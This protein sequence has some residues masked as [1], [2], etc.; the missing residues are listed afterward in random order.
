MDVASN[1]DEEFKQRI[2]HIL[3]TDDTELTLE[4]ENVDTI[5]TESVSEHNNQSDVH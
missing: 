3:F 5:N 2:W 4:V 1:V